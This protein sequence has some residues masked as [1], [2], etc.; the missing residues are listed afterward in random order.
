MGAAGSVYH[1][2]GA[3]LSGDTL[4]GSDESAPPNQV[5]LPVSSI[6]TFA[7]RKYHRTTFIVVTGAILAAATMAAIEASDASHRLR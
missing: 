6:N 2:H 4:Q 7:V 3:R 5:Q 1:L